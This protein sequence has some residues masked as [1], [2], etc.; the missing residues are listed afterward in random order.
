MATVIKPRPNGDY[1]VGWICALQ[2]ELV[3]ARVFLD[4]IHVG[5]P[6]YL[7]KNDN[8]TYLLGD[9]EG[10]NVVVAALPAGMYGTNSAA[11]VARDMLRS[12]ENV[13][14][15]LMVGIGGGAPS[16]EYNIHLGD[17]VVSV[18]QNIGHGGS[19]GVLQYKFG[20]NIQDEDFQFTGHLDKPPQIL[21]AAVTSLKAMF[22][23]NGNRIDERVKIVLE[24]NPRLV[25]KF[26]RPPA[27]SDR[28]YVADYTHP[29]SH[30]RMNLRES[31][32][33]TC[34]TDKSHVVDRN[35]WADR[36]DETM[37]YEGIIA[38]ADQLVKNARDRDDLSRKH[39]VLCFEMEA[40]GLM[41][42]F[43]CLVVRGICDYSDSHK[44][45]AWHGYAALSAA[46]Y[47]KQLLSQI[48]PSLIESQPKLI[49]SLNMIEKSI[50]VVQNT[51]SAT[52]QTITN[53][54][55]SRKYSKLKKWLRPFDGSVYHNE[56]QKQRHR[57]SGKWLIADLR[58]KEWLKEPHTFLWLFGLPGSG[59]TILSSTIIEHIRGHTTNACLYFYITFQRRETLSL[60][61]LLQ[62]LVWQLSSQHKSAARILKKLHTECQGEPGENVRTPKTN[63]LVK[64]FEQ[65]LRLEHETWIVIDALD[66]C[67]AEGKRGDF[68]SLMNWLKD[69]V[70]ARHSNLHL[71]VTSR[72]ENEIRAS[73]VAI[74]GPR[75]FI[76]IEGQGL[77]SDIRDYIWTRVWR[78]HELQ[79]WETSS[80]K[81]NDVREMIQSKLLD[82]AGGMFRYIALQMDALEECPNLKNVR[83]I[84][85][86]L[87]DSIN[88]AYSRIMVRVFNRFRDD[89]IRILRLLIYSARPLRVNELIDAIAVQPDESPPFETENRTRRPTEIAR[90]C[91]SL[92]K[93]VNPNESHDEGALELHLSHFTVQEYLVTSE[94]YRGYFQET[95][96]RVSIANICMSYLRGMDRQLGEWKQIE[97]C[98]G[99]TLEEKQAEIEA[100]FPFSKYSSESW[101]SNAISAMEDDES[102]FDKTMEFL[103]DSNSH[104]LDYWITTTGG[105]GSEACCWIFRHACSAGMSVRG[106]KALL[107]DKSFAEFDLREEDHHYDFLNI[108]CERGDVE[109]ARFL[110]RKGVVASPSHLLGK[111][112]DEEIVRVLLATGGIDGD[113]QYENWAFINACM[114]GHLA[115]VKMLIEHNSSYINTIDRDYGPPLWVACERGH[116]DVALLLLENDADPYGTDLY[117]DTYDEPLLDVIFSKGLKKVL[118]EVIKMYPKLAKRED[119]AFVAEAGKHE[120][121]EILWNN[122]CFRRKHLSEALWYAAKNNREDAVRLLLRLGAD[123]RIARREQNDE[124]FRT[125]LQMAQALGC[126]GVTSVL[127]YAEGTY[128]SASESSGE[129]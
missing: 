82:Q 94:E 119:F 127:M 27:E 67:L 1:T 34:G 17:V 29:K 23:V 102:I 98:M 22:M 7:G 61:V 19:S 64:T 16:S 99:K 88:D 76:S 4:E 117:G 13:R 81:E 25:K 96:S 2:I 90:C 12:F 72:D 115:V 112:K 58:F 92:I 62:T 37:I 10:H 56:A 42:N 126:M 5:T 53:M 50:E 31:C 48:A 87:P 122:G 104:Y 18:P 63:E 39:G 75:T 89:A 70:L 3:A 74:S 52:H 116:E 78:S 84:L 105:Y 124:E 103:L 28:L 86:N 91:S 8:N 85:K 41:N 45:D 20:K 111:I 54:D 11:S 114:S 38:S 101:I 118:A 49:D 40:A 66:E 125:P 30:D 51:T 108:A 123:G 106:L 15:G 21:L 71:L 93:L 26:S 6:Q 73:L 120:L 14:I 121:I 55:T 46:A 68:K 60:D 79:R 100:S 110:L 129:D 65:M 109:M 33:T 95:P 80:D 32:D 35:R 47:A 57:G 77:D 43:P 107:K 113:P 128:D 24:N 69:I 44:N 59:K 83:T 36:D 9:A 97:G